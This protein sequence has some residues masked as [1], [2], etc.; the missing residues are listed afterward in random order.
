M[1]DKRRPKDK[2]E[3]LVLALLEQR[4]GVENL[5][6]YPITAQIDPSS[7]CHLKCPM[8]VHGKQVAER[9]YDIMSWEL[10]EHIVGEIGPYLSYVDFLHGGE[11]LLNKR[12]PDMVAHI[13]KYDVYTSTDTHFSLKLSDA[14][15]E[16]LIDCGLDTISISLD[17]MSRETYDKYRIGGDFDLVLSNMK[18]LAELKKKRGVSRP[19]ISWQ[20]VVFS[21]NEHELPEARRFAQKLGVNFKPSAPFVKDP[22]W[23]P[24]MEEYV[25][26]CYKP[27][28]KKSEVAISPSEPISDIINKLSSELN[29]RHPCDWLYLTGTINANGSISSCCALESEDKDFGQVTLNNTFHEVWNNDK[30]QR[31]RNIVNFKNLKN[32]KNPEEI[33]CSNCPIPQ[34]TKQKQHRARI[35][36]KKVPEELKSRV[37]EFLPHQLME[38]QNLVEVVRKITYKIL[39]KTVNYT[40]KRFYFTTAK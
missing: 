39:H 9:S 26:D 38:D 3:N 20:F 5:W 17:G 30:F 12:F 2:Y 13:K 4:A 40:K 32:V 1:S 22:D 24:T 33:I 14:E 11:P 18:R 21:F 7:V 19:H 35:M 27:H 6:S 31:A 29:A 23:L 37:S 16:S 15:L 8:C 34:Y 36:M 10:Y 28:S 25:R